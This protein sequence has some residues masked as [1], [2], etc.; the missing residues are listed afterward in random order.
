MAGREKHISTHES[1]RTIEQAAPRL[2]MDVERY[3]PMTEG[4]DLTDE[5]K[6]E[7]LQTLWNI[8]VTV[9]DLGLGLD[10]LQMLLG[11]SPQDATNQPADAVKSTRPTEQFLEHAEVMADPSGGKDSA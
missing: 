11:T 9:A 7:F 2:L 1:E 4:F 6:Q 3:L 5:E 8:L 10:P